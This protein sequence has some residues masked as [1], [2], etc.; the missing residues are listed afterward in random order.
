MNR[1][2]N[3]RKQVGTALL[4]LAFCY[5]PIQAAAASPSSPEGGVQPWV[6]TVDKTKLL[7]AEKPVG[8]TDAAP[9]PLNIEVDPSR[10]YQTMVGFG[11]SI[12]DA[13]AWLIRHRM[14]DRQRQQLLQELFG[15]A[16]GLGF[17][18][19]RLTIGASDFSMS[20]Y[21]LDDMPAGQTDFGLEKFS[22]APMQV[23]VIPVLKQAMAINPQL[24]VMAS[25]WSAPAW[26][27]TNDKLSRGTLRADAYDAYA[28]YFEKFVDAMQD[29]G[30][31]IY[32]ITVQNEPH[33][34][35]HDYPSMGLNPA[36]RAKFV[37][38]HL[39]PLLA[40][41]K[42]PIRIL[43]WDHNWDEPQSP[44]AVLADEK[45][46]S[47]LAGVA[48]H[49]YKGEPS[50]QTLVHDAHP[51]KDAYFTECSGGEGN[52]KWEETFPWN[53]RNLVIGSTRNWAKSVLMWNLA[54]DENYGPHKG[55]CGDCRGVVIIDSKT[56]EV[57]RNL[58]YYAL[59][60]ASRFV[61]VGAQR[62]DSTSGVD[63]LESVAFQNADDNS[64]ALIVLNSASVPR[65]F[66]V[67]SSA[68]TFRYTLL[69]GSAA[70][71]VWNQGGRAA[72][73]RP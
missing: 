5:S 40:K 21:S 17:S 36:S 19:T 31:P 29:N 3:P 35:P 15:P 72:I 23:D 54:L 38:Q 30:V 20:H 73:S 64:I 22:I 18:F 61:R 43:E 48:W 8:F 14:D 71:F 67:R 11:A 39:G 58:D 37:G 69:P 68:K 2:P 42:D 52:A 33:F 10:R 32:A 59:A 55:G 24:T 9:L 56:G 27:K 1:N 7:S 50:A 65:Q 16:P 44:L 12:T 41:R 53:M 49:C 6:T 45:A 62:I 60:H 70:T 34:E 63:G 46:R 47:H 26:M 13:S 51:D 66:S 4:V 57:T 28:R 25:P